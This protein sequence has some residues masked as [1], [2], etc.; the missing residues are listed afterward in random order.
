MKWKL[1]AV[2]P[3]LLWSAVSD[4]C[5]GAARPKDE[6]KFGDQTNIIVWDKATQTERFYRVANFDVK[7]KDFGFIAPTPTL[8]AVSEADANAAKLLMDY[9]PPRRMRG[10]TLGP[11]EKKKD[12]VFVL[13]VAE[14]AGYELTTVK[15]GSSDSLMQWLKKNSYNT[16]PDL[17]DWL[18]FYIKKDWC[19]TAFKLKADRNLS[20]TK[21][22]CLTF[23]SDRPYNPYFVP[24]SNLGKVHDLRIFFLSNQEYMPTLKGNKLYNDRVASIWSFDVKTI[25][26]MLKLPAGT[27]NHESFLA[28]IKL[29]FPMSVSDDIF[30]D[31]VKP[32]PK[33]PILQTWADRLQAKSPDYAGLRASI[34]T[35]R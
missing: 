27:V 7:G 32:K 22:V 17:K 24:K 13:Q 30:F 11:P 26:Q 12:E 20:S 16:A 25:N 35:L 3:I 14:A 33:P 21:M 6:V 10:R 15:A 2:T 9:F 34:P 29:P 8:P 1:L 23:K 4:A 5:A 18:D 19:F 31:E 28:Y